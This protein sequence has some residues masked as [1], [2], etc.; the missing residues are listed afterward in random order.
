MGAA[1]LAQGFVAGTKPIDGKPSNGMGAA[2]LAQG[3][4]AVWKQIDGKP[5][6]GMGGAR[7][8]TEIVAAWKPIEN[9]RGGEGH[10]EGE[11]AALPR[12]ETLLETHAS[13]SLWQRPP[14]ANFGQFA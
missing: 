14:G 13:Q 12:H 1:R 8:A 2:R 11:A 10:V 7:L 9:H 5:S 4:V 6:N 3:I